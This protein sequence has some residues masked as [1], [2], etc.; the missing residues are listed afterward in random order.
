MRS[1]G[2]RERPV[3]AGYAERWKS[4]VFD[5][6]KGYD[7][8]CMKALRCVKGFWGVS[9]GFF[10]GKWTDRHTRIRAPESDVVARGEALRGRGIFL[11]C[12]SFS[13]SC[14]W[15]PR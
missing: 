9:F 3:A 7:T 14:C 11:L 13:F 1:G 6:G 15:P 4:G 8:S 12:G 5:A 2:S 10:E